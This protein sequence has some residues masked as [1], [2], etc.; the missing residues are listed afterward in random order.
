MK[1][2]QL[3]ETGE[4]WNVWNAAKT[5]ARDFLINTE[6]RRR[7]LEAFLTHPLQATNYGGDGGRGPGISRPTENKACRRAGIAIDAITHSQWLAAVDKLERQLNVRER[8]IL[9]VWRVPRKCKQNKTDLIWLMFE[10]NEDYNDMRVKFVELVNR[11]AA[12]GL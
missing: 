4:D 3:L 8:Q 1:Q 5:T 11:C 2:E 6:A 9:E 10:V 12:L 7:E